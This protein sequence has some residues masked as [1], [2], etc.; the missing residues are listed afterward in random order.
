MKD[1]ER[2]MF[3]VSRAMLTCRKKEPYLEGTDVLCGA[4]EYLLDLAKKRSTAP[5]RGLAAGDAG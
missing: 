4:V 1:R 5:Q 2:F 3:F